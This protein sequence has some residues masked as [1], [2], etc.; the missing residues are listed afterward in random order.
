M[1]LFYSI[2]TIQ[3][4]CGSSWLNAQ[5]E[6]IPDNYRP[7]IRRRMEEIIRCRRSGSIK[8]S[9]PCTK[10]L[11]VDSK[12]NDEI[13]SQQLSL[14][15]NARKSLSFSPEDSI[16][17][18]DLKAAK[19]VAAKSDVKEARK[20]DYTDFEDDDDD[21]DLFSNDDG[22]TFPRSPSFRV[23]FTNNL[24]DNDKHSRV[25]GCGPNKLIAPSG[26]MKDG[27]NDKT[28]SSDHT[29]TKRNLQESAPKKVRKRMSFKNVIPRGRQTAVKNLF[30]VR[31]FYTASALSRCSHDRAH[32]ITAKTV[33]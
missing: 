4:G 6:D 3:M 15:T 18:E 2:S 9:S 24:D 17:S 13:V 33:A 1:C 32:L 28:Q 8:A 5:S 20:K 30:H 10:E 26:S 29:L 31:S 11:L 27:T 19:K 14:D 21:E 7:I 12:A 25:R 16:T 22:M 23:Y